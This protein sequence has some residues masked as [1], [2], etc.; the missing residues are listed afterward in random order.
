VKGWNE[1]VYAFSEP[2]HIAAVAAA[3]RK[4]FGR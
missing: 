3:T 2:E 4:V 1:D